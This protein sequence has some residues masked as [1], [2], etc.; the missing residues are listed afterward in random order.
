MYKKT[1]FTTII[2][3][4]V[5]LGFC[6]AQIS[7]KIETEA[8]KTKY[9]ANTIVYIEKA[10][11]NFKPSAKHPEMDQQKLTFIPRVLP[12][13]VGSTVDFLNNDDVQHNVFSPDKCSKFDLGSYGKGVV[14][15]HTFDKEGC[16]PVILCNV[17]PEMEAYIVVLQNPYFAV[18]DKDGNYTIKGVPAGKYTLKV[19]NEKLNATPKVITVPASGKL[20]VSFNLTK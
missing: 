9:K 1:I 14:K 10:E 19:W 3:F 4:F 11:G 13:L 2:A 15:T 17:H 8:T 7:G 5:F 12:I 16:Q 6:N 20:E 18:T